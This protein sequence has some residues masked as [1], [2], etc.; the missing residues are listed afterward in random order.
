M[1]LAELLGGGRRQPWWR[2]SGATT[3]LAG[4]RERQWLRPVHTNLMADVRDGR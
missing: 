2:K 4:D 1:G 3:T